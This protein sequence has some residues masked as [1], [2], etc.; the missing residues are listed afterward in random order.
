MQ[1]E[2][3]WLRKHQV[4]LAVGTPCLPPAPFSWAPFSSMETNAD[5]E[6]LPAL[7]NLNVWAA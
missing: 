3:P 5:R 6:L 1:S 4:M 7:R 2:L